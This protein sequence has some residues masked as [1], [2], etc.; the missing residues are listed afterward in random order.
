[1]KAVDSLSTSAATSSP[2]TPPGGS[3]RP[4]PRHRDQARTIRIPVHM[5]ETIK[6][7]HPH[8]PLPGAGA[9]PRPHARGNCRTHGIPVG[10][11]QKSPQNSQEPISL[12]TPIGDEEDSAGRF[13]EDKKAVPRLKK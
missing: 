11:G 2:P 9:G 1:M 12:E 7:A 3:V 6:Q 5:I 4:S 8:L 10:K 13:I